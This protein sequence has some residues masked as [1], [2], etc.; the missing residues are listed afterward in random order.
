L[1][2][3]QILILFIFSAGAAFS[4]EAISFDEMITQGD[5]QQ[6]AVAADV[7]EAT[8]VIVLPQTSTD[9]QT[10]VDAT[11]TKGFKVKLKAK[12]KKKKKIAAIKP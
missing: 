8:G 11:S 2:S 10:Q 7:H 1:R 4:A 3:I 9:Q 5:K 12:N 6:R